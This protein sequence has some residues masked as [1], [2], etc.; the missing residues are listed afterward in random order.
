[1][2]KASYMTATEW[3]EWIHAISPVVVEEFVMYLI[4][5][6]DYAIIKASETNNS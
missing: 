6:D 1:M 4:D 2:K 5:E 3:E